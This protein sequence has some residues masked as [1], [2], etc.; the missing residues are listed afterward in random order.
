MTTSPAL[1]YFRLMRLDSPIGIYLVLWP[2]LWSLWLAAK[3]APDLSVLAI[4][5]T[6]AVLMRSAGCVINDYADHDLDTKVRRTKN[7]PIA[8]GE[9]S[10]KTALQLFVGLSVTAFIL[11]LFTNI[12]TIQLSFV[13]LG[14]AVLYPFTKRFTHIPQVVLGAAFAW[15]I[16]MAF[17]AQSQVIPPQAWLIFMVTLV[18]TVTYDTFY[19]MVDRDDDIRAGIKSIAILFGEMDIVM[20]A[21]LQVITVCGLALMGKHFSLGWFYFL[22]LVGVV[23]LFA[24]QQYLIKNRKRDQCFAAFLNNHWVGMIVFVGIA[25]HF[26]ITG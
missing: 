24:Y 5:I 16:P 3:G 18:W 10:R 1:T 23:A 15:S 17:A 21:S 14:L 22:S 8:T 25:G 11:V 26:A 7:R 13:A 9:V 4:F 19:A 12:L 20:T 2:T 6:G